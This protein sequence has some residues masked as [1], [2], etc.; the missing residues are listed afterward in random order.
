[1]RHGIAGGGEDGEGEEGEG[2]SGVGRSDGMV[3][4]GWKKLNGYPSVG[5]V[6]D[7]TVLLLQAEVSFSLRQRPVQTSPLT[8]L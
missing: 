3:Q 8:Q 6:N 7:N 4:S 1:M 2:L 5:H